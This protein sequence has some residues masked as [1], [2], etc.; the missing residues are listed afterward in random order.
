MP[1]TDREL[2][3]TGARIRLAELEAEIA[4]LQRR[5]P[6]LASPS[7]TRNNSRPAQRRRKLSRK[8]QATL[9]NGIAV[10][11]AKVHQLGLKGLKELTAYEEQ[12]T[13]KAGR[14][15]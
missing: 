10:R 4:A 11:W 6:D 9:R 3:L 1:L 8:S 12:L 2:L 7:T 13:R 15:K 5:F 14:Q